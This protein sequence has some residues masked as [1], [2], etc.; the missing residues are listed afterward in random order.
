VITRATWRPA[1]VVLHKELTDGLRD[2]RTLLMALVF[3]LLGP[4]T[5]A[6]ALH[7]AS[8]TLQK[9]AREGITLP[10]AGQEHAPNLVAFLGAEARIV[11]APAD[12]EGAVRA[13]EA[14]AVLVIPAEYGARLREGRPAPVQLVVD[15][16]RQQSAGVVAAVRALLDAW[17]RQTAAQRL[18]ARGIH[19]AVIQPLAVET[20]DLATPE[21]RAA[22]FLSILP[23]FVVMSMFMGGMAVAIDTTAGE[24]ERQSLEPLLVNPVPR[25]AFVLGKAAAAAAFSALA[26]AETL[27]GFGFLP[28]LLP[29]ERVGFAIRLDPGVLLRVLVVTLPLLLLANALMALVAIRARGF[30]QAQTTISLLMLVPAIPGVLLAL[31]PVRSQGWMQATPFLA[32]QVIISR[33]VR[34]EA[35]GAGAYL[36]A[37]AASLTVAVLVLLLTVKLFE[38][39]RLLFDR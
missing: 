20:V 24:R 31:S 19:P 9:V 3:P 28:A 37:A 10:V 18:V 33:L 29:P 2:R 7:Y 35:V 16:S 34:G 1:R 21:S 11:P 26:L 15:E 27:V 13:G 6:V 8:Q 32:E 12:P 14:D 22:I 38:S 23:Y 30:R 25:G 4:L 17:G 39:G 5:L 36:A